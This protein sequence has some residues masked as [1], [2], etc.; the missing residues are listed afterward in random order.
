MNSS[1]FNQGFT[2]SN[3]PKNIDNEVIRILGVD[4]P[5]INQIMMRYRQRF[6]K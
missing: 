2:A 1:A 5:S 6:N 4:I 3:P